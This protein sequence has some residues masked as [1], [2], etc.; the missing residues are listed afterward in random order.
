MSNCTIFNGNFTCN[1]DTKEYYIAPNSACSFASVPQMA[2]DRAALNKNK[3]TTEY[4]TN[5]APV[6]P[7]P[8][9]APVAPAPAPVAPAPVNVAPIASTPVPAPLPWSR[10]PVD[11]VWSLPP[12]L[13]WIFSHTPVVSNSL[14]H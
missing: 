9:R 3:D 11:P 8:A 1:E 2:T 14:T 6:A 13:P 10:P 4:F 5:P 7:A 12:A